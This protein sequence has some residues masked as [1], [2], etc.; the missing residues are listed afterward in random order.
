MP[1]QDLGGAVGGAGRRRLV[2]AA[3]LGDGVTVG[4]AKG[5]EAAG[6]LAPGPQPVERL[7]QDGVVAPLQQGA[8]KDPMGLGPSVA[9]VLAFLRQV[10]GSAG[11]TVLAARTRASQSTSPRSTDMRSTTVRLTPCRSAKS[12]GLRAVPG[13]CSPV[14]DRVPQPGVDLLGEHLLPDEAEE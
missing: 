8:V 10:R 6:R 11:E 2:Q 14:H 5:R 3:V 7:Q 1:H 12:C 4:G 9:A 13:A